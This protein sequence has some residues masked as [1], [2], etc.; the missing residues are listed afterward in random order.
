[1]KLA[2]VLEPVLAQEKAKEIVNKVY[3]NEFK[4]NYLEKMSKKV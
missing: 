1:M 4:K 3:K 2:E